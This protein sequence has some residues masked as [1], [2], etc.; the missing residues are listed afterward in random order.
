MATVSGLPGGKT[1]AAV[2]GAPE[3]IKNMLEIVPDGYDNTYKWFT[4]NGSRVLALGFKEM[5]AMSNER[6]RL[7]QC[8]PKPI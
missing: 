5:E 1:F 7:F 6:V 2:K 4:R 8:R 3:T